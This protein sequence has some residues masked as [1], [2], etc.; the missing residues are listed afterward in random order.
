[1]NDFW[2]EIADA[3]DDYREAETSHAMIERVEKRL[4]FTLPA[5]YIA[6]MQSRNGGYPINTCHAS[7]NATSWARDH[8]AIA[9]FKGIGDQKLWSLCGDH[10]SL[11]WINEWDYPAIG[12]YFGDCPSYGHDMM[13]LDYRAC[14][15]VGE[16][17]VV[18]VDQDRDYT[19][20]YLADSFA[21]FVRGLKPASYFDNEAE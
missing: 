4:G 17:C 1:M 2:Q 15:P 8:V 16:P 11:H 20:T 7:P 14:G 21:A 10:G 18:H 19:I 6:L 9:A 13:C 5:S 12:I 3:D